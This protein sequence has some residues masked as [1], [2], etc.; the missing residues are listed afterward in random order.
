MS[1][2]GQQVLHNTWC[3]SSLY[4]YIFSLCKRERPDRPLSGPVRYLILQTGCRKPGQPAAQPSGLFRWIKSTVL[5]FNFGG[6]LPL[7]A[8]EGIL[9]SW[10]AWSAWWLIMVC[11]RFYTHQMVMHILAISCSPARQYTYCM[12]F[13]YRW[14]LKGLW[15]DC[16]TVAQ[17]CG[18]QHRFRL[19]AVGES[20]EV[21]FASRGE[22]GVKQRRVRLCPVGNSTEAESD[23]W[24]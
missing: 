22:G 19:C 15:H 2:G 7:T 23:L 4:W 1:S 20:A 5:F 9:K 14:S 18:L 21:Y 6:W 12:T 17:R 3:A 24:L 13:S 16:V 8:D 11:Y 10:A